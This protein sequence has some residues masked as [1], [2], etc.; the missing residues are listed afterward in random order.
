M[1]T[2]SVNNLMDV[3]ICNLAGVGALT[4]ISV[5]PSQYGMMVSCV[6]RMEIVF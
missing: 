2:M 4:T 5:N 1:K 3:V 6:D